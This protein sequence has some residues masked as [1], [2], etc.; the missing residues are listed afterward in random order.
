MFNYLKEML[1]SDSNKSSARVINFMG[2]VLGASLLA[3]DTAI[4]GALNNANYIAFLAYCGMGYGISKGF[5]KVGN[6]GN[7]AV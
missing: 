2:A 4:H 1:S 5:D 7:D 3:Y 6:N